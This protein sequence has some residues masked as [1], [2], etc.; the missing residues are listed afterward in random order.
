MASCSCGNSKCAH[1]VRP[2]LIR[3]LVV[4]DEPDATEFV[5]NLPEMDGYALIEQ[6]RPARTIEPAHC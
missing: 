3:V 1:Q 2:P 5:R 6:I 4:E